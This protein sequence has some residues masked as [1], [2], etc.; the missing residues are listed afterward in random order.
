MIPR[1]LLPVLLFLAGAP[2]TAQ[3]PAPGNLKREIS[4]RDALELGL[5]YNYGL[6]SA[7]LR[8]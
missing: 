4:F 2:A 5:A 6:Q 7:R 3:E 1:L 8:A